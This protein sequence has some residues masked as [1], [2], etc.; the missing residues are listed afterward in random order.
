MD[1]LFAETVIQ[2]LMER[3]DDHGSGSW[4]VV[5]GQWG[6]KLS[7]GFTGDLVLEEC[8]YGQMLMQALFLS[9]K[10]ILRFIGLLLDSLSDV[11][12]FL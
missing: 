9:F 7:A 8:L 1:A 11:P 6:S 5:F 4:I 10:E 3:L 2:G 12:N